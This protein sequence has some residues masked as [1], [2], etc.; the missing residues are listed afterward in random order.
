MK[1]GGFKRPT[2]ERK[3]VPPYT[4][5]REITQAAR[6]FMAI[7]KHEA[8]R[9]RKLLDLAHKVHVC[10]SCGRHVE[11]GCEPAHANGALW[12][13]GL[14]KK[15]DD[16]AHAALCHPCHAWLDQGADMSPCGHYMGTRYGKRE[17]WTRA[18]FKTMSHY[19]REGWIGVTK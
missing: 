7:P 11:H 5:T 10:Q 1:R 3:P 12:G 19:W 6:A 4:L 8:H 17:M 15:A 9:D 13:K 18:H 16:W 14:A 2:I